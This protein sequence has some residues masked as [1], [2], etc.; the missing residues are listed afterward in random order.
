MTAPAVTGP[1][2][3]AETHRGIIRLLV[4]RGQRLHPVLRLDYI[5]RVTMYPLFF[6]LLVVTNYPDR[7]IPFFKLLLVF[8][9]IAWPYIALAIASRSRNQKLAEYR[10][11]LLDSAVIG[12]YVTMSWFNLGP[13]AAVLLGIHSGCISVGGWRM[14]VLGALSIGLG[15]LG[16]ALLFGLHFDPLGGHLLAQGLGVAMIFVYTTVFSWQSHGQ[17]QRVVRAAKQLEAQ[18]ADLQ[19]NSA[20]LEERTHQLELARDAAEAANSSKS[21]FLANMSHELRTPLNAI[22]GY[23]DLL[24][25]EAE[26]LDA[27]DLVPDLDKIRS[28]GKHLLGLIN[29]VLDLSKIEAGKMEMSLETFEVRDVVAAVAA[30]VRPLVEKNGNVFEMS[31]A[32]DVGTMHADLTRVRQI[33]LNLLGNASKFT[34]KGTVSLTVSRESS[35][36][37]EWVVFAVRDTGIGMTAEQLSRLF[38]PFTQA[39]P[40]TTR[41]YGG[42]GLGLSISQRLSRLMSG[43]ISVVSEPGMGSIFTVRLPVEVTESKMSRQTGIYRVSR[44][45]VPIP[46]VTSSRVLLIDDDATTRDLV[47][48]MLAKDGVE[49]LYAASGQ[50]GLRLAAQ[51]RPD[52]IMLDVMLPDQDGWAVL[53]A[54]TTKLELAGIP[55][56]VATTADERGLAETLGAAAYLSKPVGA[57]ELRA[58]IRGAHQAAA[59]PT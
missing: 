51:L 9:V 35:R 56:I 46:V 37:R 54:L 19:R 40:S 41:K 1:M 34:S 45:S 42:T 53:T 32:A 30:M 3:A 4:P 44:P 50:E 27:Q 2:H 48:R 36:D 43:T 52:V 8:H 16:S 6:I 58:A 47:Q 23:S 12:C 13:S 7:L 26:E 5:V 22:I 49:M 20:L 59:G 57:D 21:Q 28:S 55:V 18:S 31:I 10:N 39:D 25:E 17:A 14:G 24:I 29:D 15:M 38:Q 33:L 11:L